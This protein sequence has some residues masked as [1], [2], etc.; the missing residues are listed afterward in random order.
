M[1]QSRFTVPNLI[2]ISIPISI[3][4]IN[5]TITNSGSDFSSNYNISNDSTIYYGTISNQLPI[6]SM[7]Q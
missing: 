6:S 5:Y 4:G 2:N 7:V 3:Q 1:H